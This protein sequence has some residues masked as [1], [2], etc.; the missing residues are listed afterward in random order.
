MRYSKKHVNEILEQVLELYANL[1]EVPHYEISQQ[2]SMIKEEHL[3]IDRRVSALPEY[4][5]NIL[6]DFM[7]GLMSYKDLMKKYHCS[8]RSLKSLLLECAESDER[9]YDEIDL[10]RK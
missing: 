6:E 2:I 1:P 9:V 8:M 3:L 10:R 5:S 7:V 4:A